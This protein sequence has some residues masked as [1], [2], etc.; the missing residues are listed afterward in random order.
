MSD[1]TVRCGDHIKACYCWRTSG[2]TKRPAQTSGSGYLVNV[3]HG[4]E[5]K[6]WESPLQ[7]C[8]GILNL[9][10]AYVRSL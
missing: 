6:F 7:S 4:C 5:V 8:S 1:L 3:S 9:A 2:R 10:M